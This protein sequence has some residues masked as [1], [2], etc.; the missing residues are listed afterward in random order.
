MGIQGQKSSK[1]FRRT[2]QSTVR[3][4]G[5]RHC[6]A[7]LLNAALQGV[8]GVLLK[9]VV[10]D[11]PFWLFCPKLRAL[12]FLLVGALLAGIT[13]GYDNSLLNGLQLLDSWQ[14]DF[15]HPESAWLGLIATAN[16]LGA[17]VALPFVSPLLTRLGRRWPIAC[18]SS[19]ILVGIVIQATAQSPSMFIVG[20]SIL[21]SFYT[22][23]DNRL[24]IDWIH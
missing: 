11:R 20:R 22:C 4:S 21:V 10:P 5:T 17:V 8:G 12:N 24:S 7:S 15:G 19:I 18:G 6:H 14:D 16:R 3:S 2:A 23:V 9:D 1:M 13:N